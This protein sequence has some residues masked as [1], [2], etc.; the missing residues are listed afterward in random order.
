VSRLNGKEKKTVHQKNQSINQYIYNAPW[1]RGACYS[2]DYAETKKN[3][4]SRVLTV[5]T[6]GAFRQFR[7]R[8]FQSL[9]A[10]TEKQRAAVSK[11]C[12]GTDRIFCVD[13]RSERDWLYGLIRS[14]A[15]WTFSWFLKFY[16]ELDDR[17]VA[18][19]LFHDAGPATARVK[20]KKIKFGMQIT[21]W[22]ITLQN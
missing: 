22:V 19:G 16:R 21:R 20:T 7:G 13:D 8:E 4:L 2:A 12:G 18:G 5:L 11:L 17:T 9:G 3:V 15:K 6:D 14:Q 1:Y 10:A